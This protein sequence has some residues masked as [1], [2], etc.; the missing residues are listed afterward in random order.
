MAAWDWRWG[1]IDY[2]GEEGVTWGGGNIL[3][4]DPD[5]CYM[6]VYICQNSS[7]CTLPSTFYG[8]KI[9]PQ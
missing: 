5:G 8:M 3:Y 1:G 7:N 2:K 4:L 6:V 9:R